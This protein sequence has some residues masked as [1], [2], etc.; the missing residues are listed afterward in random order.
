M[1]EGCRRNR[2][3]AQAV[4]AS[5]SAA[6]PLRFGSSCSRLGAWRLWQVSQSITHPRGGS[7]VALRGTTGPRPQECGR[8]SADRR[9][10]AV[11]EWTVGPM[12]CTKARF[13][14]TPRAVL[15]LLRA[16]GH[17][18][19]LR[20]SWRLK[21]NSPQGF[22]RGPPHPRWPNRPT[23]VPGPGEVAPFLDA[24]T[25]PF[26]TLCCGPATRQA[27]ASPSRPPKNAGQPQFVRPP[28][29]GQV[30][31]GSLRQSVAVP[32]FKRPHAEPLP[33]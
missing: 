18:W 14:A 7:D 16:P 9:S 3:N 27:G 8:F 22:G 10:S 25:R 11:S 5:S 33:V 21:P 20:F 19:A 6:D 2:A 29:S 28:R 26:V 32:L 4:E 1:R 17:P 31:Q 12:D 24:L 15:R 30:G 23:A 13:G